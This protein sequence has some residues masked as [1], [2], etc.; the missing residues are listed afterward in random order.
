[1][2]YMFRTGFLSFGL[3]LLFAL[4]ALAASPNLS[5]PEIWFNGLGSADMPALWDDNA[6]WQQAS[7]RVNVIVLVHWWMRRPENQ[8]LLAQ[9]VAY[10]K[11][12]HMKIALDTEPVAKYQSQTCGGGEGYTY[13]GEIAQAVQILA[14][15]GVRLDWVDMDEPMWF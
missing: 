8:A 1:M 5:L 12:H 14:G 10:A 3:W 7:A 13:P 15:M 9:I 4:S 6:S 2:F 11:R